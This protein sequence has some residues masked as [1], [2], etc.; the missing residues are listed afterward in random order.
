MN[1]KNLEGLIFDI[2]RYAVHD[3]PG[4]RTLIFLKGCPL[5]CKW[6]QNPESWK[7]T[8]DIIFLEE[9]CIGCKKCL[10]AC[11][12]DAIQFKKA[13]RIN[14]EKCVVPN[15]SLSCV[16]NCVAQAIQL[17]G[18]K[19]PINEILNIV[20]KDALYYENSGGGITISGGEPFYQPEFLADFLKKCKDEK[21]HAVIETCGH[22]KWDYFE[23]ILPNVDLLYYDIKLL[24]SDEHEKYTGV[25]NDVILSNLKKLVKNK[26]KNI[27]IRVPIVSNINDNMNFFSKLAE[28]MKKLALLEIHI[29]PYH[30]LAEKKYE[31]LGMNYELK[32]IPLTEKKKIQEF[33]LFLE[34]KG[35]I[36][37]IGGG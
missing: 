14:R 33:K 20:K 6:C 15:C 35:L 23:K 26:F 8:E 10:T 18:K 5:R 7:K 9:K 29:L 16:K 17:I 34:S 4:I 19:M 36:V 28:L 12:H 13:S 11:E 3:G 37:K 22:A 2:Q 21:I 30:R 32:N 1:E 27:V 24:N 25:T 31:R